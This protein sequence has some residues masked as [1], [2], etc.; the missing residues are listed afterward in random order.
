MYFLL[1]GSSLPTEPQQYQPIKLRGEFPKPDTSS[2]TL[3]K[4]VR[5]YRRCFTTLFVGITGY[6]SI[7]LPVIHP[8]AYYHAR[9]AQEGYGG[10]NSTNAT[11]HNA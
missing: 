9:Y 4:L 1:Q 8:G 3:P 2:P 10:T 11:R 6:M 7:R 5:G